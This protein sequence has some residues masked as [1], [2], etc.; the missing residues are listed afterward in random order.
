MV[1][2]TPDVTYATCPSCHTAD[3]H[4]T[5]DDL[6]AGA[7]WRCGRCDQLWSAVRLATVERYNQ[8]LAA[9]VQA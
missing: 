4:T 5:T 6:S 2:H 3:A 9:R 8:W 7:S 1:I